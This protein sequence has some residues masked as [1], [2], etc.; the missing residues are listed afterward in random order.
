MDGE[1]GQE[2]YTAEQ[3]EQLE[4][5]LRVLARMIARAH[6]QRQDDPSPSGDEAALEERAGEDLS[7]GRPPAT[8][9]RR[10]G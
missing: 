10:R 4:T 6:L 7:G 2:T 5:G 8:R 1:T 3:R 9:R